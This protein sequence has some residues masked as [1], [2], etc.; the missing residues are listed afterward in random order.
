MAETSSAAIVV[1]LTAG[2]QEEAS[3]LAEML[4]GAH[5]AACVQILPQMESVYRWKGEVHRA[6]E[7]LLLAK[8]TAACFDELEREV[9]ALHTYDTPEIIA[10]PVTHVSAPYFDWLT[11]NA[12]PPLVSRQITPEKPA[13]PQAEN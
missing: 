6:P 9:R 12:F 5:L 4:V 7:F 10:M 11:S 2:S 1:L 13:P 8:T 3:R